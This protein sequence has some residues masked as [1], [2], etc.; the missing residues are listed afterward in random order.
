MLDQLLRNWARWCNWGSIGPDQPVTCAS[1][2][3]TYLWLCFD[4]RHQYDDEPY[5]QTAPDSRSAALVED[6]VRSLPDPERRVVRVE[7]VLITV[8]AN[9]TGTQYFERKRRSCL[10]PAWYYSQC[11]YSAREKLQARL[12]TIN[13]LA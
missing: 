5:R 2:E 6:G 3:H 7:Y 13:E 8:R 4:A 1:A 9:E 10:M 11:L 12:H